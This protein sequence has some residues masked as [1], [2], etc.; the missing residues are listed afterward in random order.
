VEKEKVKEEK[1]KEDM[2]RA[3]ANYGERDVVCDRWRWRSR[4][5]SPPPSSSP[6]SLGRRSFSLWTNARAPIIFYGNTASSSFAIGES[7]YTPF[8]FSPST[9]ATR[10]FR[11]KKRRRL[12]WRKG[13]GGGW[14]HLYEDDTD[15]SQ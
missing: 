4:R 3:S 15:L 13:R 12:K 2:R 1:V 6:F 7:A 8:P 10:R 5:R 11:E 14:T 9:T